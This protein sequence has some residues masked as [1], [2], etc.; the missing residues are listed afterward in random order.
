MLDHLANGKDGLILSF[1]FDFNDIAK[2]TLEGMLRSVAFQLY[3]SGVDSA[4]HLDALFQAHRNG[5]DQPRTKELW[6]V[7]FKMLVEQRK[8][9][10]VLD[11]LDESKTRDTVFEWIR[12][13][14]SRPELVHVQL[15]LTGRP[16]SEFLRDI[17]PLIGEQNSLGLDEKAVNSDIRSW[18]TAQLSRRRDFTEKSLSQNLV[19]EIRKKV[20]D[21][22]NWMYDLLL[23]SIY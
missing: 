2:Q 1:F 3:R 13:M 10:I 20:G 22:A 18:V 19:E 9:Y 15:F 14:V 23:R 8:V 21:S 17:P 6:S 7:V 16:E 11:A 4:N 12:D 5:S